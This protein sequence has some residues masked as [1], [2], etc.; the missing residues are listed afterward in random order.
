M[1]LTKKSFSAAGLCFEDYFEQIEYGY[2][3]LLE[4]DYLEHTYYF[5]LCFC[6][7]NNIK[8]ITD[9]GT[10]YSIQGSIFNKYGIEY[11]VI[12][13]SSKDTQDPY[14]KFANYQRVIYGKDSVTTD[15]KSLA[16]A[17]LSLGW[18]CYVNAE[19][20]DAQYKQ[21]SK[22]F[23]SVLLYIPDNN[24]LKKYFKYVYKLKRKWVFATNSQ[25]ELNL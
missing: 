3:N 5:V 20:A 13:S 23:D 15:K 22:D 12:S 25:I 9:I 7:E 10:A 21:L 8:S 18:P 19:E 14:V 11:N 6:L 4:G 2:E 1:S 16:V 24:V 17:S